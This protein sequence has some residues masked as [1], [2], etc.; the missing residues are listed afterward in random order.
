[1]DFFNSPAVP[2]LL[3]SSFKPSKLESIRFLFDR[4]PRGAIMLDNVGISK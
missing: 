3:S 4:L 1:M 2:S